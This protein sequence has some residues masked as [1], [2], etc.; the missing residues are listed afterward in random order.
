MENIRRCTRCVMDNR[1]DDTITFDEYG[2]CNYCTDALK[3]MPYTYFPNEEGKKKLNA[4]LAEMKEKGKGKKYDCIM[5]ISGG[6]DSS[7][8]AMLGYQWGLRILAVHIDDG[9]DAPVAVDNIKKLCE[10]AHLD[11]QIIKPDAAQFNDLTKAYMRA[12]VADLAIP[13][14]NVLFAFLYRFMKKYK[15]SYF[16]SGGNFSLES[17]LQKGN[18][19]TALDVKNIKAIHKR[20]GTL[21]INNLHFISDSQKVLDRLLYNIKTIRPL[22]FIDYNKKRAIEEL[23]NFCDFNYYEAKHLENTLTK[24]IQLYW[25]YHKFGVD[26]R[27]SHLSSLIISGQMNRDEAIEELNKPVYDEK[28]ME[29]DLTE[30]LSKL[31]LSRDEFDNLMASL[32]HQHT[33]YPYSRHILFHF[34][35]W[36]LAKA[37]IKL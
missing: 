9:F 34:V 20:F 17:I 4:L 14:D 7:Y 5:G 21:P 18:S 27:T 8:L 1:S 24:V 29:E 26:K 19:Y 32:N 12:G 6:L 35:R 22:D 25:F 28:L 10:K 2:H 30:V 11:L 33:D 23:K 13:Q 36:C 31:K 16:L 15:I 37:K 3:R